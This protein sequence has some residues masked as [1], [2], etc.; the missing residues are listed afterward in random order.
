MLQ[1]NTSG[2]CSSCCP[3]S[4]SF[5]ATVL[6]I[7][8]EHSLSCCLWLFCYRQ[9]FTLPF[10]ELLECLS[11]HFSRLLS[12]CN[13]SCTSRVLAMCFHLKFV[14]HKEHKCIFSIINVIDENIG[15]GIDSRGTPLSQS[16]NLWDPIDCLCKCRSLQITESFPFTSRRTDR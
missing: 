9:E 7:Q 10:A 15:S 4:G 5:F 11:V 12:S 13:G 14:T 2:S 8:L 16:L 6:P 3:S 1:G